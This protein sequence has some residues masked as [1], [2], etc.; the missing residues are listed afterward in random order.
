MNMAWQMFVDAMIKAGG[1]Y[2]TTDVPTCAG[3]AP[4]KQH[5]GSIVNA[6]RSKMPGMEPVDLAAEEI[7]DT[8]LRTEINEGRIPVEVCSPVH[9]AAWDSHQNV[10]C[11]N[12][13]N[14]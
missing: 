10:A 11:W 9:C 1:A 14:L 12:E 5:G 4:K 3:R 6:I 8:I 13:F 7:V 2:L